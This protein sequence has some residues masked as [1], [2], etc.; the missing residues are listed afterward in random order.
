VA[1][2]YLNSAAAAEYLGFG[3]GANAAAAIRQLVHRRQ[4]PFT[5]IGPKSLRFDVKELD[6]WMAKQRVSAKEVA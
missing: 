6:A 2:R 5:R 1:P 4:I 3:T